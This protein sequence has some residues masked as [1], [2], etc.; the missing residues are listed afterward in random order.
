MIGE[1]RSTRL[2]GILAALWLCVMAALVPAGLVWTLAVLLALPAVIILATLASLRLRPGLAGRPPSVW[3]IGATALLCLAALALEAAVSVDVEL[4]FPIIVTALLTFSA[5]VVRTVLAFR[6]PPGGAAPERPSRRAV[7]MTLLVITIVVLGILPPSTVRLTLSKNSLDAYART[8]TAQ[9]CSPDS[10]RPRRVGLYRVV[11][12]HTITAEHLS[13]R[14]NL[15]IE[16]P[17]IPSN[18][19]SWLTGPGTWTFSLQD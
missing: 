10:F 17:L 12:A 6:P 18:G 7:P 16:D 3:F 19:I 8:V 1:D 4:V 9:S 14:V 5:V 15:Q 13:T 2:P 11:C